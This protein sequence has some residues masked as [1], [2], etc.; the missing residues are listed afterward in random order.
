MRTLLDFT[1]EAYLKANLGH[2]E[3]FSIITTCSEGTIPSHRP[4][5]SRQN[6]KSVLLRFNLNLDA[7]FQTAWSIV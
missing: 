4:L 7:K 6:R 1:I 3:A 5:V 2:L